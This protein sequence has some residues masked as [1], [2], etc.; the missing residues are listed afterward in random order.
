M[1]GALSIRLYKNN[2]SFSQD[3]TK[4]VI[5]QVINDP[6]YTLEADRKARHLLI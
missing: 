5:E 4:P 2:G 3:T 1:S 6:L